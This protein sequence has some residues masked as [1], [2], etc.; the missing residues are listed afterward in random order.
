VKGKATDDGLRR[1][2]ALNRIEQ[3]LGCQLDFGEPKSSAQRKMLDPARQEFEVKARQFKKAFRFAD[4]Q[5]V[6]SLH[7]PRLPLAWVPLSSVMVLI[8]QPARLQP[9]V[10]KPKASTK[11]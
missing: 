10:H 4:L 1:R 7:C 9:T 8:A 5:T 2:S 11:F 3:W 6:Q